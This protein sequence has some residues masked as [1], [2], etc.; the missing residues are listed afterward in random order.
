MPHKTSKAR[1]QFSIL[2][3]PAV[4]H[5]VEVLAEANIWTRSMT[6]EILVKEALKAREKPGGKKK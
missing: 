4:K 1:I 3:E 6:V 2:M 5:Q